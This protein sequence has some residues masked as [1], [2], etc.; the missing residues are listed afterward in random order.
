MSI[1]EIQ[2]F[3]KDCNPKSFDFNECKFKIISY[4]TKFDNF[5]S[6]NNNNSITDKTELK[7]DIEYCIKVLIK[8]EILGI[9]SFILSKNTFDKKI[10]NIK[11]NNINLTLSFAVL[12]KY[13][14]IPISK[15]NQFKISISLEIKINYK[16]KR[17]KFKKINPIKNRIL[18]I[19]RN[20][21]TPLLKNNNNLFLS[22][23]SRSNK[24]YKSYQ[25]NS[26]SK[27]KREQHSSNYSSFNK[28][29]FEKDSYINSFEKSNS[30]NEKSF[31]DSIIFD[32]DDIFNNDNNDNI[33][34]EKNNLNK[35]I[36]LNDYE[37]KEKINIILKELFN[38]IK[39]KNN[40]IKECIINNI[41]LKNSFNNCNNK[42]KVIR[43]KENKLFEIKEKNIFK[44]E[45]LIYQRENLNKIIN[46]NLKIKK[47][48]NEMINNI[49]EN[50]YYLLFYSLNHEIIK[51]LLIKAIKS[52]LD[53]YIDLNEY[54]NEEGINIFRKI[55]KKYNLIKD[56][57][58]QIDEDPNE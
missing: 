26:F 45:I 2:F 52:N 57:N 17:L 44:D 31:I 40:R 22:L 34:K 58:S 39:E 38:I 21:K 32:N 51:N 8:G 10:K 1:A 11:I 43:M 20:E 33:I 4:D 29:E 13:F 6:F 47:I 14:K 54:F 50:N 55:C 24:S 19:N 41:K 3:V 49:L 48:E 37:I 16:K 30:E 42:I 15:N 46:N 23:T 27:F 28:I 35:E 7:S 25:N 36:E 5:I 56:D 53:L 9:G 18:R 12:N